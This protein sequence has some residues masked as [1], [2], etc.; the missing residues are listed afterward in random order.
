MKFSDK[1]YVPAMKWRQGEMK[2]IGDLTAQ[3][4]AG[5]TPL[6]EIPPI[7]WDYEND[8]PAKDI[9]QHLAQTITQISANWG[10]SSAFLDVE[11]VQTEVLASGMHPILH[12][13][14]SG[15]QQ[16]LNL[17]PVTGLDRDAAYMAALQ[18]LISAGIGEVGIRLRATAIFSTTL[19]VDLSTLL[20]NLG[21]PISQA[22]VILDFQAIDENSA[23]MALAAL[24]LALNSSQLLQQAATLTFMA[25]GFPPNLSEI[26]PGIGS[27]ER[28]E[29]ILWQQIR[30]VSK[31]PMA[32]G[33]YVISHFE[34]PELNPRTMRVSASIRYTS[35]LEWVIFRGHWLQSPAHSGYAQFHDLCQQ[36]VGHSAYSGQNFSA[37]DNTIWECA[38]HTIG[39]GNLTTWRQVGTNHHL[40][41][42]A[43][44]IANLP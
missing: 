29:W 44:Q 26:N 16:G 23:S 17:I 28:T 30:A 4:K 25:T 7:P 33:D 1:H 5:L 38:N 39:T 10:T 2:A 22:H 34:S 35:T 43:H 15:M 24:P 37:G 18:N 6:I 19:D 21:I 41:F 40:V 3:Q 36:I 32:F 27:I 11:A 12:L 42:V 20:G 8:L 14:S 9:D 13:V 31:I